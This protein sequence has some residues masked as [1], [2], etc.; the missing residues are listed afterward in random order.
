MTSS[1]SESSPSPS[2][3][4]SPAMSMP[5]AL[6]DEE[7]AVARFTSSGLLIGSGILAIFSIFAYWF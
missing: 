6:S 7:V 1:E 2:S 4:T 3:P 5:P